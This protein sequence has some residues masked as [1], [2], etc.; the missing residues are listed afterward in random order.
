[1]NAQKKIPVHSGYK[2]IVTDEI[3]EKLRP[4]LGDTLA[5]NLNKEPIVAINY[6]SRKISGG[7]NYMPL[8]RLNSSDTI[9]EVE[10]WYNS[11]KN[12][13]DIAYLRGIYIDPRKKYAIGH[14]TINSL[15]EWIILH[16]GTNIRPFHLKRLVGSGQIGNE[17]PIEK[18]EIKTATYIFF[19]ENK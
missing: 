12:K 11:R 17:I 7:S 6:F 2:L 1:M 10:S 15:H 19:S 16:R 4:V 8:R 9:N 13:E 18:I 3:R 5:N 14:I